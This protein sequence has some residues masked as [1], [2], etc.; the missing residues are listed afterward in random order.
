M[1]KSVQVE[2]FID[3]GVSSIQSAQRRIDRAKEAI[4]RLREDLWGMV[5]STPKDVVKEGENPMEVMRELFDDSIES[6]YD[7]ITDDY[8]YTMVKNDAEYC[9]DSLVVKMWKEEEDEYNKMVEETQKRH[10]FFAK[11]KGVLKDTNFDD[12]RIYDRVRDGL[13][14]ADPFTMEEREKLLANMNAEDEK[15]MQDAINKITSKKNG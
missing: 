10:A 5:M 2:L 14:L 8:I 11:H 12:I 13:V 6:L 15:A 7:A 4:S 3:D 9:E 1:S